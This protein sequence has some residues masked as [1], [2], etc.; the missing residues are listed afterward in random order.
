MQLFFPLVD[1]C[2]SQ[3]CPVVPNFTDLQVAVTWQ[4]VLQCVSEDREDKEILKSK[5]DLK[6]M[7]FL[8]NVIMIMN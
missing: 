1:S 2:P 4:D 5:H 8:E 7:T 6:N 3:F